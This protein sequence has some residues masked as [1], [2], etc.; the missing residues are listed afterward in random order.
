MG[1][2]MQV[3]KHPSGGESERIS[4]YVRMWRNL[5]KTVLPDFKKNK[6]DRVVPEMFR[7]G[8]PPGARWVSNSD[9]VQR[10]KG[11]NAPLISAQGRG[12]GK[13]TLAGSLDVSW[14]TRGQ[15]SGKIV[16]DVFHM[17]PKVYSAYLTDGYNAFTQTTKKARGR[18]GASDMLRIPAGGGNWIFRRSVLIGSQRGG[19]P[20]REHVVWLDEDQKD[21]GDRIENQIDDWAAKENRRT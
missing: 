13:D 18:A 3:S 12:L 17:S 16:H 2:W 11:F 7:G 19:M 15:R 10:T 8:G 21:L 14:R 5:D 4:R 20:P 1:V 6:L 9:W